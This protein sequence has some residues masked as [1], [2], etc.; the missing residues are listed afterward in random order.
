VLKLLINFN[1]RNKP[2]DRH[3]EEQRQ[4]VNAIYSYVTPPPLITTEG[5]PLLYFLFS[6]RIALCPAGDK[7]KKNEMGGPCRAYWGRGEVCTE[8]WW[9]NLREGDHW[10]DPGLDGSIILRRIFGKWNISV[11]TGWS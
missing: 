9:G 1:W 4:N 10:E 2:A 6:I 3:G 5:D 7:I 11:W 8:F